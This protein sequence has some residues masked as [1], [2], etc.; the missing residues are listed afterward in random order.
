M[1]VV[2]DTNLIL[3]GLL[4]RGIPRQIINL[5]HAKEIELYGSGETYK[6]FCRIVRYSKFRK[7]LSREI[8]T[9]QKLVIDYRVLVRMVSLFDNLTGVN[10]VRDDPDDDMFFRVAKACGAKFIVS[11]D[12]HLLN[13][14]KYDSIR[15]VEPAIFGEIF[16]KLKGRIIR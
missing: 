4:W 16:P 1:K 5:A 15:V 13:I 8:F 2:P 6:E 10:I 3:S 11:G 12:P 9:P 14:E 7:Y